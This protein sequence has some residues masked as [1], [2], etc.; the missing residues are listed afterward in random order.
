MPTPPV[1]DCSVRSYGPLMGSTPC[2]SHPNTLCLDA[3]GRQVGGNPFELDESKMWNLDQELQCAPA[4]HSNRLRSALVESTTTVGT[5]PSQPATG[6]N[7]PLMW[8]VIAPPVVILVMIFAAHF[9]NGLLSTRA[10]SEQ[11]WADDPILLQAS[12]KSERLAHKSELPARGTSG[13]A[14]VRS[15]AYSKSRA[16]AFINDQMVAEGAVVDGLTVAKIHENA[17]EFEKDGKQWTQEVG[18]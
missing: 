17:V 18:Q 5:L 14:L 13:K 4:A 1:A 2:L 12:T 10:E 16:L 11:V 8:W 6:E 15:I 9:L 3:F 7:K